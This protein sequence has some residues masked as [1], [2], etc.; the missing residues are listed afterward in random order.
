MKKK[1]KSS[2]GVGVIEAILLI[3]VIMIMSLIILTGCTLTA[4][5]VRKEPI[6]GRYRPAHYE[7]NTTIEHRYDAWGDEWLYIPVTKTEYVDEAWEILYDIEYDNGKC[8]QAWQEVS[9]EQYNEI[10]K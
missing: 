10:K 2:K 1:L 7:T 5:V 3:A 4:Q 8:L 9:E 6:R